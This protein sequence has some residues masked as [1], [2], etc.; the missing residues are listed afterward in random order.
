MESVF[1]LHPHALQLQTR[2]EA[3]GICFG[4][5]PQYAANWAIHVEP[6]STWR[7]ATSIAMNRVLPAIFQSSYRSCK[8]NGY[9]TL[10]LP[11]DQVG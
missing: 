9:T 7:L 6:I 5:S 10:M 11:Q 2:G 4:V 1:E 3:L 8:W